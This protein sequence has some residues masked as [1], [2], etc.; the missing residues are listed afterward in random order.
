MMSCR[1][2]VVVVLTGRGGSGVP[3]EEQ[4]HRRDGERDRIDQDR[5]RAR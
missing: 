5:E 1:I 2:G 4:R 3:D